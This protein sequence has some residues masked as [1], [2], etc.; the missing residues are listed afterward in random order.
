MRMRRA[1]LVACMVEMRNAYKVLVRKPE[2]KKPFGIPWH[3][4][5]HN[6]RMHLR[7][8]GW[9]SEDCIYVTQDMDHWWVLVYIVMILWVP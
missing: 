5:E 4:W 6:I 1:G 8:R 7:E 3:R 2:G 9:E